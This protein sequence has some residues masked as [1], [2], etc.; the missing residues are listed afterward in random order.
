MEKFVHRAACIHTWLGAVAH[1]SVHVRRWSRDENK[2]VKTAFGAGVISVTADRWG[3]PT[4][5]AGGWR[6]QADAASLQQQVEAL[7]VEALQVE[8]SLRAV[9]S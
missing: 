2:M 1:S 5:R 9:A 6:S 8:A 7:Q 4:T 3:W